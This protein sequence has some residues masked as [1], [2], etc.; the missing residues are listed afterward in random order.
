MLAAGRQSDLELARLA[1]PGGI[2]QLEAFA[3]AYPSHKQFRVMHADA[4]CQYTVGFVF[5]DWEDAT[6]LGRPDEATRL[7]SRLS[8]LLSQCEA[9]VLALLPPRFRGPDVVA[10]LPSATRAEAPWL[11]WLGSL[12]AVRIAL[13]P[14]R[15]F[16][17]LG[18]VQALLS[19]SAALSP[20]FRDAEAE[21]L[22]GTL[23][24]AAGALGGGGDPVA[25]FA[26]A[27]RAVGPS[28]LIVEVMY[29]RAVAVARKDPA[30]FESTLTRVLSTD[31]AQWPDRRLANELAVVKARRYLAAQAALFTP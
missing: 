23:S 22:L 12:G 13:D 28:G 18:K 17:N 1:L 20:G 14:M 2:V 15:E 16:G 8:R 5:D 21:L 11:L 25:Y 26:Q 4:I 29:A 9:S 19:R 27:R 6:L 10:Q 3:L 31:L 24:A 7:A 30:L